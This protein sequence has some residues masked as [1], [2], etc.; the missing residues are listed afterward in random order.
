MLPYQCNAP[1]QHQ[2][3]IAAAVV[4][5]AAIEAAVVT[6]A[7]IEAVAAALDQLIWST[8][9]VWQHDGQMLHNAII[10]CKATCLLEHVSF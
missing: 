5:A 8:A 7:A 2:S 6:A 10:A 9:S 4:T 3:A 1:S